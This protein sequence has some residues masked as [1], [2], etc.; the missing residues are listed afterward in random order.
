MFFTLE[1]MQGLCRELAF[2]E[3]FV[4]HKYMLYYII[5]LRLE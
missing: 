5:M 1:V 3:R 4:M 2:K